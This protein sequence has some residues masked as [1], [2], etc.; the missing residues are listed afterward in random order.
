MTP[1]GQ[2]KVL[3]KAEETCTSFSVFRNKL[4]PISSLPAEILEHI[5][6]FCISWIYGYTRTKHCLAWTQ[7]CFSWRSISFNSSRLWQCIDLCDSRYADQFLVRSKGAP[8]SVVSTSPL[9]LTTDNLAPHAG[10]LHSIDVFLF[11][12]D[13]AHLFSSIGGNLTN[14]KHLSLKVPQASSPL[15]LDIPLPRVRRLALDCI[16]V[17]WNSCCDLTHLTLRGLDAESCPSIS[18]LHQLFTRSPYIESI[19]LENLIPKKAFL[20]DDNLTQPFP[21]P[22]LKDMIISSE[23]LAIIALLGGMLVSTSTRLQLHCSLSESSQSIF[24]Y[25][26][27]QMKIGHRLDASTVRLSRHS[28][29]LILNKTQRWSEDV[30]RSLFSISSASDVAVHI[31]KSIDHLLDASRITNL[32]LNTGV[33]FDISNHHMHRL[34]ASLTNLES[35]SIA[36]NNLEEILE[37]LSAVQP[38]PLPNL[39]CP[40]LIEVSFSKPANMWWQFG[41]RWLDSI[42]DFARVRQHHSLPIHTFE[43]FQCHGVSSHDVTAEKLREI[44]SSVKISEFNVKRGCY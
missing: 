19:R 10:R 2:P 23:P 16:A 32:E 18:Q 27:P 33:L 24:P 6:D 11:P 28:V 41:G 22:H 36:F 30:T 43:F 9:K 29:H 15:F 38:P 25:G 35:L 21:L 5:F 37:I 31:C 4:V 3:P 40:R 8:L 44:V 13:M 7:V 17:P 20:L 1:T 12:N 26:I 14:L 42:I 34:L 39:L